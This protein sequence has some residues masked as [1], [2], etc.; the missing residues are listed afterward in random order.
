M[1][2]TQ[3]KDRVKQWNG[4]LN[5]L[6]TKELGEY[7]KPD[8][9][10]RMKMELQLVDPAKIHGA[11]GNILEQFGKVALG[12]L[13][14]FYGEKQTVGRV[15]VSAL[16]SRTKCMNEY[17]EWKTLAV[18]ETGMCINMNRYD[19]IMKWYRLTAVEYENSYLNWYSIYRR[20]LLNWA[21]SMSLERLFR[22]RKLIQSAEC[23]NYGHQ[24]LSDRLV[25]HHNSDAPGTIG[26]VI[27]YMR[28][29]QKWY[30]LKGK[31]IYSAQ[32]PLYDLSLKK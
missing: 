5:Q 8:E 13:L 15:E 30:D 4:Q 3:I 7:Y 23:S 6:L 29:L 21:S 14:D 31:R 9:R 10:V 17:N 32:S 11:N 27:L 16:I 12:K 20:I 28:A 22:N 1:N 24:G 19:R 2:R 25:L 18:P 26:S